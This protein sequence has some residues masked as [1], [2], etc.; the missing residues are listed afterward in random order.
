[1]K[2]GLIGYGYWGPNILRNFLMHTNAY[3]V[4]AA[5]SR[6]E[7]LASLKKAHPT[8]K[9]TQDANDVILSPDVDAV[10]IATPVRTHFELCKK[11]L[12]HGKHVLVEKPLAQT[13]S[14]SEQ[15]VALAKKR[16]LVLMVDHT[17]IY[18]GAVEKIKELVDKKEIGELQYFDSSRINLGL[19]Q[20]DINVLW[21]LAPHDLSIL[22][23]IT[24][25]IPISVNAVGM[26]HTENNIENIAYLNLRYDNNF[27]AHVTASWTSPVKIR[28]VLIGGTKKMLV[29]NDLE[30]TEKLKVYETGYTV[31]NEEEKHASLVDYRTG[32]IYIPKI[33]T[34]EALK[35]VVSDFVNSIEK[36]VM[37]RSHG[38][39][40]LTIVRVLEAA[41]KSIKNRGIEVTLKT[42]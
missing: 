21:D 13:L 4:I 8:I 25:K 12:E 17:Y 29:Y 37:P 22:L 31:K 10:V 26:C 36:K 30:P 33:N 42:Q 6:I 28:Q 15:L 24:G 40:G 27:I 18:A 14:E 3:V 2:I 34:D 41:E 19:F 38:E 20:S 5:D 35:G 11:A 1:M 9:T 7:R 23:Y 39:F 32:D 16:N